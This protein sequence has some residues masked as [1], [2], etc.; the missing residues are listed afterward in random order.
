MDESSRELG[1]YSSGS[2][3]SSRPAK[4]RRFDPNRNFRQHEQQGNNYQVPE[5]SGVHSAASS[6]LSSQS[7]RRYP[8]YTHDTHYSPLVPNQYSPVTSV[9]PVSGRHD[10]SPNHGDT[11]RNDQLQLHPTEQ[12]RIPIAPREDVYPQ[13]EARA[14]ST[15][16]YP[17]AAA[18]LP[19]QH[20]SFSA[21][22]GGGFAA[23][24]TRASLPYN[25]PTASHRQYPQDSSTSQVSGEEAL[26][27]HYNK[28]LERERL[29]LPMT[30]SF[31]DSRQTTTSLPEQHDAM[32]LDR[33]AIFGPSDISSRPSLSTQA[34]QYY[35]QLVRQELDR[36]LRSGLS[37]FPN[38][39]TTQQ[40]P[41]TS[42]RMQ[43]VQNY[44]LSSQTPP[45]A[46]RQE[47]FSL[48]YETRA[49]YADRQPEGLSYHPLLPPISTPSSPLLPLGLRSAMEFLMMEHARNSNQGDRRNP[50]PGIN[51]NATILPPSGVNAQ[52][53]QNLHGQST[54]NHVL[55]S[56]HE[57]STPLVTPPCIEGPLPKYNERT[58]LP[59]AV[60]DNEQWCSELVKFARYALVEV[61]R[62]NK[63]DVSARILNKRVV[64]YQV[65]FR[66]RF[67]A[68]LPRNERCNR[69]ATFPSSTL[70]IRQGVA[71]MIREHFQQCKEI[72]EQIKSLYSSLKESK[73]PATDTY[74]KRKW[75]ESARMLGLVDTAN[76]IMFHTDVFSQ[77][78]GSFPMA[79]IAAPERHDPQ[80][81]LLV[82]AD[83]RSLVSDY[84][85]FLMSQAQRI[86]LTELDQKHLGK[87]QK[88]PIG[89]AGFGCRYCCDMSVAGKNRFFPVK[90]RHIPKEANELFEHLRQCSMCPDEIKSSMTLLKLSAESKEKPGA[91]NENEKAFCT[92][93]WT[94]LHG[95]ISH[96]DK[97]VPV[98]EN[99][100]ENLEGES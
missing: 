92:R 83:D 1:S 26:Y 11:Y 54:L 66:C 69:S 50:F 22:S 77:Q 71:V 56:L 46:S 85:Y 37:T 13:T 87:P 24:S 60:D 9:P 5:E 6:Y 51:R 79:A 88:Q 100:S 25:L 44:S 49:S 57:V 45:S 52:D 21:F 55:T 43:Q 10:E 48:G 96:L 38:D 33:S 18:S 90:H 70:K 58:V 68:H 47:R 4:K 17:Y 82:E 32:R 59:L 91:D 78:S 62:A 15:M 74:S 35:D 36:R 67:C 81:D 40:H 97:V 93:V 34:P 61:F 2:S 86:S 41:F 75:S 84:L 76:G 29:G 73:K 89:T 3:K 14:V 94:R 42:G 31:P 72:P 27:K 95:K 12:L 16:N 28:Q 19:H 63:E 64:H 39:Q 65:G 20:P 23:S 98:Y 30:S 99:T 80:H 8:Q 7:G 53:N